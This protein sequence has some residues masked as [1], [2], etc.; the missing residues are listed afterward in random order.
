MN[1]LR[2]LRHLVRWPRTV[3]DLAEEIE[4]HRRLRRLDFE[5][6]GMSSSAATLAANR[7]MGNVT[8]AREDAREIWLGRSIESLWQDV[9]Y[10]FRHLVRYPV[11]ALTAI[12]ALG[13]A[14]AL[15]AGLF[16]V[17]NTLALHPWPVSRPREVFN[18][19]SVSDR[20]DIGGGFSVAHFRFLREHAKIPSGLVAMRPAAFRLGFEEVGERTPGFFVS[21]NY[22]AV[23]GVSM[24]RGRAFVPEEDVLGTPR[25]VA[26]ISYSLWRDRF[27][28][29]SAVVGMPIDID[30]IPVIVVG[31]AS[32]EFTGTQAGAEQLWIPFSAMPLVRP[33][34]E[35]VSAL[36]RAPD[37]CCSQIAGRIPPTV[38]RDRAR[39]ELEVL[40][41]QFRTGNRLS[42]QRILLTGT[43][44]FDN[45]TS[46]RNVVAIFFL[47]FLGGTLVLLL[48]CANVGNLLLARAGARRREIAIRLSLGASRRRLVRQLMTESIVLAVIAAALG[49]AGAFDAVNTLPALI[50]RSLP[51]HVGP[52]PAVLLY[53]LALSA[54]SSI[55]FGL[56]PALHTSKASVIEAMKG[57]A[58]PVGMRM[59]LR[60][61]LLAVQVAVSFTLLVSAGLLIRGVRRVPQQDLGFEIEHVSMVTFDFPVSAYDENRKRSFVDGYLQSLRASP[62]VVAVTLASREPLA[63]SRDFQQ[64]RIPGFKSAQLVSIGVVQVDSGYFGVLRIPIATG[65]TF[66]AGALELHHVVVNESMA[67]AYWPGENAVGKTLVDEGPS[68]NNPTVLEVIGVARDSRTIDLDRLEPLLYTPAGSLTLPIVLLRTAA[69][70]TPAWLQAGVA[71]ID[72]RVHVKAKPLSERVNHFLEPTRVGASLAGVLGTF[73]LALAGVG[74]FG[75]FAYSLQQR[76]KEIG[77]RMALGARPIQVIGLILKSSGRS[78]SV[79]LLVGAFGAFIASRVLRSYLFGLSALDPVAY[80]GVAALLI[81]AAGTATFLPARRATRVDPTTALRNE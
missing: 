36:L 64:L 54:L 14:I 50:G 24:D 72:P 62:G 74:M 79:G 43:T 47:M 76:T 73:A 12:G 11:F 55:A 57:H 4:H 34:Q 78:V 52:D 45:P 19:F 48:A 6:A 15:N 18:V 1:Y 68:H 42:R 2:R 20:G 26:V 59:G 69:I 67:R 51:V 70:G 61:L 31:V 21:G 35:S 58:Q 27:G 8:S 44:F 75:V 22:F 3:R 23:L 66:G 65:R 39:A 9:Q 30:G 49:V 25:A 63:D 5:R 17:F 29:D 56:A 77:I 40:T 71:P 37:Y 38:S 16:A 60:A 46:K 7:A 13:T 53:A 10:A 80:G 28:A 33:T 41:N 81:L 32:H